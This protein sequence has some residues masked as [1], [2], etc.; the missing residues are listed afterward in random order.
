[1]EANKK[2]MLDKVKQE[3]ERV[4]EMKLSDAFYITKYAEKFH[5]KQLNAC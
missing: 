1:L 3:R 2:K 5:I 4:N